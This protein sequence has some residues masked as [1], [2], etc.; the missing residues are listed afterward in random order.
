[1]LFHLQEEAPAPP[2]AAAA[3]YRPPS[4]LAQGV[5]LVNMNHPGFSI[6]C[7]GGSWEE[8]TGEGSWVHWRVWEV[9]MWMHVIGGLGD[10]YLLCLFLPSNP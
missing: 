6:L 9:P 7:I 4:T 2:V 5:A 1:M 10:E 3:Q 8:V